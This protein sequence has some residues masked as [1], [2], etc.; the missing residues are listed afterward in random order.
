MLLLLPISFLPYSFLPILID[1]NSSLSKIANFFIFL[2]TPPTLVRAIIVIIAIRQRQKKKIGMSKHKS[3]SEFTNFL[4][5]LLC[6]PFISF[7]FFFCCCEQDTR[8]QRTNFH[9]VGKMRK[10]KVASSHQQATIAATA[11]SSS[12]ALSGDAKPR[13]R[14]IENSDSRRCGERE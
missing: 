6:L 7:F 11:A 12:K 10:K 9:F 4:F 1:E 13:K 5:S 14:Q 2:L 8:R 3:R